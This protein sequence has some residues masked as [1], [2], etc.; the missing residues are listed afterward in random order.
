V[1][2]WLTNISQFAIIWVLKAT[3]EFEMA[4]KNNF[5]FVRNRD[6]FDFLFQKHQKIKKQIDNH[7]RQTC[8]TFSDTNLDDM[9]K[10]MY[11]LVLQNQHTDQKFYNIANDFIDYLIK[12]D[13]VSQAVAYARVAF[14][15]YNLPIDPKQIQKFDD[16]HKKYGTAIL[17]TQTVNE[18]TFSIGEKLYFMLIIVGFLFFWVLSLFKG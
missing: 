18:P 14:I 1:T 15:T 7:H 12:L 4:P 9:L 10:K 13:N 6:D 2:F 17:G 5:D 11:A 8:Q 3:K 16:F